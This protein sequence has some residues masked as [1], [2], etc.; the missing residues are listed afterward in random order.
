M[1][2]RRELWVLA[3]QEVA[4]GDQ[5]VCEPSPDRALAFGGRRAER[6]GVGGDEPDQA[7]FFSAI[8]LGYLPGGRA[9]AP[10]P[11]CD[12][13]LNQPCRRNLVAAPSGKMTI[14]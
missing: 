11:G 7:R 8:V 2:D 13:L 1:A 9:Q 5:P 6:L 3:A 14:R 10:L 12:T 4:Q